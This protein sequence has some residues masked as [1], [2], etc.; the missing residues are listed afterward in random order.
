MGN[1]IGAL[2]SRVKSQVRVRV[3]GQR[4]SPKGRLMGARTGQ[5][6]FLGPRRPRRQS[7]PHVTGSSSACTHLYLHKGVF[8]DNQAGRKQQNSD[9]VAR[10]VI[11]R[12]LA[13][14]G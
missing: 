13:S 9:S 5:E 8:I 11:S 7:A 6:L 14:A 4:Q 10:R 3:R 1:Q 12:V 2:W